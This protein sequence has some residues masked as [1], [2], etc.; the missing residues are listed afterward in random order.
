[1]IKSK[2]DLQY[3]LAKDKAALNVGGLRDFLIHDIWRFQRHLRKAEYWSNSGGFGARVIAFIRRRILYISGRKLGFSIPINTVGAGLSIA[4][5]GTIV[6]NSKC[7]IGEH[8]RLH[9]CVNIGAS[10]SD[11]SQA[12]VIGDNC[13]IAPGVKIYGGIKIGNNTG[14]GAN[15]VVNKSFSE[16]NITIAGAPARKISDIG[17]NE[18]RPSHYLKE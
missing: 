15:S 17:P 11:S 3:Y 4:H 5:M 2:Q 18:F 12:P 8:C 6:I 14:I 1:M 10:A 16:G 13:Y 7:R 9:V